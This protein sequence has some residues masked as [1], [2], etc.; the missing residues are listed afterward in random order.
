MKNR[1]RGIRIT[2]IH[3]LR[4]LA[5]NN[6]DQ[7]G[8]SIYLDFSGQ[9]DF[10][11]YHRHNGLLYNLLENGVSVN[12][13]CRTSCFIKQSKSGKQISRTERK[14]N[15]KLSSM[16]THLLNVV[17]EFIDERMTSESSHYAIVQQHSQNRDER[18]SA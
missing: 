9:C 15:D 4:I 10:L 16:V 13:L 3:N 6:G 8:F 18:A 1:N 5:V 12:E 2:T 14:K 17:S 11:M 7:C